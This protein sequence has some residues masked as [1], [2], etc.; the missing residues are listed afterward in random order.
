MASTAHLPLT[1]SSM[2]PSQSLYKL[3]LLPLIFTTSLRHQ[4]KFHTRHTEGRS[5]LTMRFPRTIAAFSSFLGGI[6]ALPAAI[7]AVPDTTKSSLVQSV[8][9][10][11]PTNAGPNSY[12]HYCHGLVYI[13]P[14]YPPNIWFQAICPDGEGYDH[15]SVLNLNRC[16]AN[17]NGT[18]VPSSNGNFGPTCQNNYFQLSDTQILG[19]KCDGPDGPKTSYIR[20]EEFIDFDNGELSCFGNRGCTPYDR[21]CLDEPPW[22]FLFP[23]G[24]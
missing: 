18:M 1:P 19:V 3:L 9:L 13:F 10:T 23:T 4:L 14:Q 2:R 20:L 8:M 11:S 5:C 17:R 12:A 15:N 21:D 16:I 22:P 6:S 24:R 7:D